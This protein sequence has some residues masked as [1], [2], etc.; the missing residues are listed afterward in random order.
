MGIL[1]KKGDEKSK[2]IKGI[3]EYH[4]IHIAIIFNCC[5]YG[6]KWF[7]QNM[8]HRSFLKFEKIKLKE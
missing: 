7:H 8:V 2:Y 5:P 1:M 6:L 4:C 3:F